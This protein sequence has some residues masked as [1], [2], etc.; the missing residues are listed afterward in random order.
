MKDNKKPKIIL[1]AL[2][3]VLAIG[4]TYFMRRGDESS[5]VKGRVYMLCVT[6]ECGKTFEMTMQEYRKKVQ[7]ERP[8]MVTASGEMITFGCQFCGHSTVSMAE[9]C[10]KCG[11]FFR[12][13]SD[14]EE[15]WPDRCPDC[16]YSRSED[17]R[18]NK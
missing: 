3:L 18:Q 2:C 14:N 12:P 16:G 11:K 17:V 5:D 13:D 1:I 10:A 9:K 15:D 4:I 8:E 7:A 6:G